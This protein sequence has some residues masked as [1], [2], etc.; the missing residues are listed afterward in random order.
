M[1][2]PEIP[3]IRTSWTRLDAYSI[4]A[5]WYDVAT[6][7]RLNLIVP[8]AI[9]LFGALVTLLERN[10]DQRVGVIDGS[11]MTN[12]R[13]M[14]LGI[15]KGPN[16]NPAH[17]LDRLDLINWIDERI[18]CLFNPPA[19]PSPPG[20]RMSRGSWYWRGNGPLQVVNWF[21]S[22]KKPNGRTSVGYTKS[23]SDVILPFSRL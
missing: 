3:P 15:E 5:R 17:R 7:S 14:T 8:A 1:V 11:G 13:P 12:D 21:S 10:P 23:Y 4:I 18:V 2:H 22:L 20:V 6:E 19:P 9:L 16:R